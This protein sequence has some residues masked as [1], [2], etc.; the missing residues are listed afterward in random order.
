VR[1]TL[2]VDLGNKHYSATVDLPSPPFPR[3]DISISSVREVRDRDE[4]GRL[5]ENIVRK[6][7]HARDVR[8]G[9][10]VLGWQPGKV[11]DKDS[12]IDE[13]RDGP[14]QL[15]P[16]LQ[17]TLRGAA[18][19]AKIRRLAEPL[20]GLYRPAIINELRDMVEEAPDPDLKLIAVATLDVTLRGRLSA[21]SAQDFKVFSD[22]RGRRPDRT[23]DVTCIAIVSR[24]DSGCQAGAYVRPEG[25]KVLLPR[26]RL[27]L[28]MSGGDGSAFVNFGH[29][30]VPWDAL[31]VGNFWNKDED[32]N[33]S[34]A[35]LRKVLDEQDAA[36]RA[37]SVV[38]WLKKRAS[39]GL[40]ILE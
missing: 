2:T 15:W 29:L 17:G 11:Y 19:E 7:P 14:V 21:A 12:N 23:Q 16:Q 37:N 20:M 36:L 10:M 27:R 35:P 3:D 13:K 25:V 22:I 18:I 1:I 6:C 40:H 33:A 24:R 30:G 5:F 39:C 38:V 4:L 31:A 8:P 28:E 9:P 34:L 26:K 32:G